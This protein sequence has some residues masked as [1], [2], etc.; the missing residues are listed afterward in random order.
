MAATALTKTNAPGSYP[1]AGTAVT[2]GAADASNGNYFIMT[3][4]ELVL[5][6]NSH[7]SAAKTWTLTSVANSRSRTRDITAES[8][9]AGVW[10]VVGPFTSKEGWMQQGGG[11]FLSGEDTSVK[12][13]VLVLPTS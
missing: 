11:C 5:V 8:M 13:G 6:Q 12:F 1:T 7:A 2:M 9:A 4:Q 10:K 3:G